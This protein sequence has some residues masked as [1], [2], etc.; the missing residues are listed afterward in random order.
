M[1]GEFETSW[2]GWGLA[3]LIWNELGGSG[4]GW[5]DLGQA[6]RSG[7]GKVWGCWVSL[8]LAGEVWGWL[9]KFANWG[10]WRLSRLIWD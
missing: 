1:L 3:G 9:G 4:T 8:K 10:G 7:G 6:G 5:A 2:G